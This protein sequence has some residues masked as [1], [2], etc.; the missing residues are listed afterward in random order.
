MPVTP[1]VELDFGRYV[2]MRRGLA[3]AR[4]RDGAAT[5]TAAS[6]ASAARWRWPAR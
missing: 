6:T 3:E 1:E 5:P 2:A 4:E